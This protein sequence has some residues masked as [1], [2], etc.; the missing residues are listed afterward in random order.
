MAERPAYRELHHALEGDNSPLDPAELHGVLSG[1]I[2]LAETVSVQAWL[3]QSYGGKK[4]LPSFDSATF[5]LL[6]DLH[7]DVMEDLRGDAFAF[8]LY[9][10]EPHAP[11]EERTAQLAHWC[12]GFLAALGHTS[13]EHWP[14]EIEE[15]LTD[16]TEI[17]R[18]AHDAEAEGSEDDWVQLNEYCR[19]GA[20]L[21]FE[22]LKPARDAATRPDRTLQ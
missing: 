20:M 14:P 12:S 1:L 18:A 17:A 6:E 7:R 9:M 11:L 10:D 16:L 3:S 19:V 5:S 21:V 22:T 2:C 15:F 4:H 8:D 13:A